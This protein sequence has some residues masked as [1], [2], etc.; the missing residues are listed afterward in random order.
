MGFKLVNPLSKLCDREWGR[1]THE[2]S[3][4]HANSYLNL[5]IYIKTDCIYICH[6]PQRHTHTVTH[7]RVLFFLQWSDDHT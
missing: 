1:L 5:L 2:C 7:T 6:L 4:D 3:F